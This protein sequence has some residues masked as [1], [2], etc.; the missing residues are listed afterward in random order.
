MYCAPCKP[1]PPSPPKG[2]ETYINSFFTTCMVRP[3]WGATGNS[4][5]ELTRGCCAL[6]HKYHLPCPPPP[7]VAIFFCQHTYRKNVY[8]DE[9]VILIHICWGPAGPLPFRRPPPPPKTEPPPPPPPHP[10]IGWKV[11]GSRRMARCYVPPAGVTLSL[12]ERGRVLTLTMTTTQPGDQRTP[13]SC[14]LGKSV[15]FEPSGWSG[16]LLGQSV[17]VLCMPR[18]HAFTS[19][20]ARRVLQA[21]MVPQS[22]FPHNAPY[23]PL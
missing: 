11:G 14:A 9:G 10:E 8:R 6:K 20:P 19:P 12:Q 2:F 17:P 1:F 23:V 4:G 13:A 16:H 7:P 21:H 5:R 3:G 18:S 22:R 15:L